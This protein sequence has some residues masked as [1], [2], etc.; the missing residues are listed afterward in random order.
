MPS[1]KK[2]VH[3]IAIRRK[4]VSLATSQPKTTAVLENLYHHSAR[5]KTPTRQG[6]SRDIAVLENKTRY[7]KLQHALA[8][9]IA[10]MHAAWARTHPNSKLARIQRAFGIRGERLGVMVIKP[11]VFATAKDIKRF[12]NK[13]GFTVI[14]T[15]NVVF[16]KKTLH[17]IYWDEYDKQ[18]GFPLQAAHFMGGPS[19][20]LVFKMLPRHQMYKQSTYLDQLQLQNPQM[21]K[22]MVARL[23]TFSLPDVFSHIIKG[24]Y[25]DPQPGTLRRTLVNPYFK[26]L[27]QE[28]RLSALI[29]PFGYLKNRDRN[30][31]PNDN[32]QQNPWYSGIHIPSH[33][34]EL[35]QT[36]NELLTKKELNRIFAIVKT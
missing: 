1:A 10:K 35:H 22:D 15:K 27:S 11:E 3:E 31:Q 16:T 23:D 13:H 4:N 17:T 19:K 9:K 20:I 12:L 7:N 8:N 26:Q 5:L 32:P 36:A 25:F 29:D 30:H 18:Y 2:L 21:Y 28:S 24:R 6:T 14:H 34:F 33:P